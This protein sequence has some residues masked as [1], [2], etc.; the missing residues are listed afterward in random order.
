MTNHIAALLRYVD[1]FREFFIV[2]EK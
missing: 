1:Q 2:S